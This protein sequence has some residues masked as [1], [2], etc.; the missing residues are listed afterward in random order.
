[1]NHQG[2]FVSSIKHATWLV[3]LGLVSSVVFAPAALAQNASV[4]TYGGGANFSA[5]VAAQGG[6][7]GSADPV[8][9][10][11]LPFTGLDLVLAFG[12][13]LAL[14]MVGLVLARLVRPQPG[15]QA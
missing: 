6:G 15:A 8:A 2:G 12:G 4:K 14:L 3:A 7:S 1:M 13:G 10:G 11:G 9:A 5:Q